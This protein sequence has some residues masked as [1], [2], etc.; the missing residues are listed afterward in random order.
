MG[1]LGKV[2]A[3]AVGGVLEDPR[4]RG[5]GFGEA[6]LALML[7]LIGAG[8]SMLPTPIGVCNTNGNSY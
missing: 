1:T 5:K 2:A 3:W 6:P 8:S 7:L 4:A